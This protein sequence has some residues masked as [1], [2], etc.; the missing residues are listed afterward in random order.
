MK[1]SILNKLETLGD[2]QEEIAGLLADPDVMS[3]QNQFRQLSM[4]YS[5]LDPVVIEYNNYRQ[6]Q[7]DKN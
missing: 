4:E 3:D 6:A 2:R 5:Q 1:A 7:D